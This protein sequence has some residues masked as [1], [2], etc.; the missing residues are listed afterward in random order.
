MYLWESRSRGKECGELQA[1]QVDFTNRESRPGWS[2]TEKHEPSACIDLASG[3]RGRFIERAAV[4]MKEMES[5][6][7]GGRHGYLFRPLTRQ[8]DGFKDAPLSAAVYGKGSSSISKMPVCLRGETLHSFRRFA[9]QNAA[10]IEGYDERRLMELGRWKS[11]A[12]FRLYIEEI[13]DEFSRR[14]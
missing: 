6:G 1:D 10:K 9:V 4:L 2:K 13:E 14:T 12:A 11:Y 8:R 5:M 3:Y 7:H